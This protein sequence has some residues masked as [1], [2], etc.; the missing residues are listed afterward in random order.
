MSMPAPCWRRPARR[1]LDWLMMY[2]FCNAFCITQR[3]EAK[4]P[5][6][7]ILNDILDNTFR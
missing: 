5:E 2:Q 6:S 1:Q 3:K 7:S 4:T